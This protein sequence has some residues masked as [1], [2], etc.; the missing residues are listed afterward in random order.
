MV[1]SWVLRLRASILM[2][3]SVIVF[4]VVLVLL[5]LLYCW[6]QR[7]RRDCGTS[8]RQHF[9]IQEMCVGTYVRVDEGRR[10]SQ[11][12]AQR[13]L[14]HLQLCFSRRYPRAD[15]L[16]ERLPPGAPGSGGVQPVEDLPSALA[17]E[18]SEVQK[19]VLEQEGG[20]NNAVLTRIAAILA[21]LS[22]IGA[23][24]DYT[25]FLD[26]VRIDGQMCLNKV[27]GCNWRVENSRL[28]GKVK[29]AEGA[30]PPA[31]Y[32]EGGCNANGDYCNYFLR[33]TGHC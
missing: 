30:Y 4:S 23:A 14:G 27:H 2:R 28:L 20:I 21:V 9:E 31:D 24:Y 26:K 8:F 25:S 6:A 19:E 13:R 29:R 15:L 7:P 3:I 22:L 5:A 16:W 33:P 11:L 18:T 17:G 32:V 1:W 10:L 12:C